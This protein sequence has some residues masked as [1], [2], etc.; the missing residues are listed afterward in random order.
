[1]HLYIQ[2][3]SRGGLLAMPTPRIEDSWKSITFDLYNLTQFKNLTENLT[4]KY[5]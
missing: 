3:I 2:I 4:G 5:V 1:M